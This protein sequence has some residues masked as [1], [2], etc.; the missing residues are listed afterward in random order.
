MPFV[1]SDT[2][3]YQSNAKDCE[4]MFPC[5]RFVGGPVGPK[6]RGKEIRSDLLPSNCAIKR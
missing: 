5:T 3:G 2:G 6:G 1:S 4:V